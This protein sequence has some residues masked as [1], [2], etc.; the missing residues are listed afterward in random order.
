MDM[1][2]GSENTLTGSDVP[3]EIIETDVWRL[4]NE[5][6]TLDGPVQISLPIGEQQPLSDFTRAE[7]PEKYDEEGN[8]KLPEKGIV[9]FTYTTGDIRQQVQTVWPGT[10]TTLPE[11]KVRV[12]EASFTP[13]MTYIKVEMEADPEALA[14]F[15]ADNG[16]EDEETAGMALFEDWLFSLQLTDSEGNPIET[17]GSG[18]DGYCADRAEFLF[19]W[20]EDLP[21]ELWLAP[22]DDETADMSRAVLV[23]PAE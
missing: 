19:A 23:R 14:A 10:E 12:A 21:G 5:D 1:P 18:L 9:T 11:G 15:M 20:Q 8:M 2:E 6:V 4:D 17:E 3:G 16:E 22:A 13:L 7:H